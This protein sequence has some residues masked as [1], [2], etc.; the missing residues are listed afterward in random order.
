MRINAFGHLSDGNVYFNLSPPLGRRDF[1]GLDSEFAIRLGR[2]ATDM[3]GSFAAEHGIGRT[4]LELA[5]LLRHPVERNLM[6]CPKKRW[7]TIISSTL[8][9]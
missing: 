5:D 9:S 3:G 6:A 7:M 8:V 1:L 4:K 2:L